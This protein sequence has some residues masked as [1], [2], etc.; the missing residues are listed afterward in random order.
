VSYSRPYLGPWRIQLFVHGRE[1][2]EQISTVAPFLVFLLEVVR[3]V[4]ERAR[5]VLLPHLAPVR[6]RV[7]ACMCVCVCVCVFV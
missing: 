6:M 4:V 3:A 7:Y 1:L 5:V 2:L